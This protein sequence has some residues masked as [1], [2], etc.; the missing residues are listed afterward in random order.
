[1]R[2]C[3]HR[4]LSASAPVELEAATVVSAI[5][6]LAARPVAGT[7]TGPGTRAFFA[8]RSDAAFRVAGGLALGTVGLGTA[9]FT[10]ERDLSVAEVIER[11][12]EAGCNV[13]DLAGN[14]GGGEACA[15]VGDGLQ[16]ALLRGSVGREQLFL[17]G[18]AGFTEHLEDSPLARAHGWDALGHCLA[19]DYL[20]WEFER[21]CRWLGVTALDAFLL[22]NPEELVAH[23]AAAWPA[24]DEAFKLLE[25]LLTSGRIACYGVSTAEALR[26]PRGDPRHLDLADLQTAACRAGGARHG[27]RVLELP[28]SVTRL[29]AF[30]VPAHRAL[31]GDG[32]ELP[33]LE[34]ARRAGMT[35]LASTP[36]N[37]GWQLT[38]VAGATHEAT[39]LDDPAA[40][41]LQ[42]A[43]SVPAVTCALAGVSTP[44]HVVSIEA[45]AGRQPLDLIAPASR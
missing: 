35:V 2:W 24:L 34:W 44:A 18:K 13:V 4:H 25:E 42:V 41:L 1:M 5:E 26:V 11:A 16:R 32:E 45:L 6:S 17:C 14:H 15:L 36:L 10:F 9:R 38:A 23:G 39:G 19:P 29:E 8:R 37:G 28:V 21:Q 7:A 3:E 40:S 22:Q 20:R 33:A 31:D 30:D 43:R 27:F 12:L